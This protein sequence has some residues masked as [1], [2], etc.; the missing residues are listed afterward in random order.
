VRHSSTFL[1]T[2]HAADDAQLAPEK[3]D[4]PVALWG[5]RA[6]AALD[7]A[8]ETGSGP[9]LRGRTQRMAPYSTAAR[10]SR[11][12]V[13]GYAKI[14]ESID[15]LYTQVRDRLIV[16]ATHMHAAT[17]RP[18]QHPHAFERPPMMKRASWRST[19]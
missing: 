5:R 16:L 6:F 1:R 9:R 8:D 14:A 11:A 15:G 2:G 4:R 19:R 13:R 7:A 3:I 12:W 18:R 10:I 17:A